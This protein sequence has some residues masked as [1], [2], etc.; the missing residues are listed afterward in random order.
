MRAVA[1]PLSIVRASLILENKLRS[2][3]LH[4]TSPEVQPKE[5]ASKTVQQGIPENIDF[6]EQTLPKDV[7]NQV[8]KCQYCSAAYKVYGRFKNHL[9]DK[10]SIT[11]DDL[12]R[13]DICGKS[14]DTVK[15]YNRHLKSH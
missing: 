2:L 9:K 8:Y 13:C 10:H 15:K 14:F 11:K 12:L 3:S 6:V 7:T 1:N 5:I 4:E